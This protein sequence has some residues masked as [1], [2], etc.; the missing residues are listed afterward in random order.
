MEIPK[1]FRHFSLFGPAGPISRF[2]ADS[3]GAGGQHNSAGRGTDRY[4]SRRTWRFEREFEFSPGKVG[5]G[6]SDWASPLEGNFLK[7]SSRRRR[8]V[9]TRLDSFPDDLK[10]QAG[11]LTPRRSGILWLSGKFLPESENGARVSENFIVLG[12]MDG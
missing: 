2:Q 1:T 11:D 3:P 6:G 7:G 8:R 9:S 12:G 10:S 5:G 4:A